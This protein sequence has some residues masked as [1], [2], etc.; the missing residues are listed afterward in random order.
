MDISSFQT[1]LGHNSLLPSLHR[2]YDL[3]AILKLLLRHQG[4]PR[5]AQGQR[6]CRLLQLSL[7]LEAPGILAQ[8]RSWRAEAEYTWSS[9]LWSVSLVTR[10]SIF[11]FCSEA[12]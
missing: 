1:S 2:N 8:N 4:G 5:L 3:V 12:S 7:G 11:A 9:C 10:G 6:C